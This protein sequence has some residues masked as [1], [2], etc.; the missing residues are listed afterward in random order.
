MAFI[1]PKPVIVPRPVFHGT[2]HFQNYNKPVTHS[3]HNKASTLHSKHD[4]RNIQQ[5]QTG[6]WETRKAKEV[7]VDINGKGT[8]HVPILRVFH[9]IFTH[10][11]MA[12]A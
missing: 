6:E 7:R 4:V 11:K 3:T 9:P 1:S 2:H 5:N 10:K 12:I 8:I